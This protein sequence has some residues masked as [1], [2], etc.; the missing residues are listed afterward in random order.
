MKFA[1]LTPVLRMKVHH[2]DK[3]RQ[4]KSAGTPTLKAARLRAAKNLY[5]TI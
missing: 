2:I 3:K 5:V 4:K 1:Y